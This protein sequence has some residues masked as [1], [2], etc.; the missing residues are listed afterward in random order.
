MNSLDFFGISF[1]NPWVLLLLFLIPV[2]SFLRGRYGGSAAVVFSGTEILEQVGSRRR[3][4]AG[5]FLTTMIYLALIALILAAGRP[6]LGRSVTR[7]QASGTDIMLVLDVSRSMLA[8]DFTIGRQRSNRI[9]AVRMVTERFIDSRP[10][11][12][13]G[14]I[15]FAGRP[16]LVSPLTLH[17]SWLRRNLDRIRIGLVEDGTAIGSAIAMA[18]NRLKD[19][20]QDSKIMVLLTD[21]DNNMGRI[22]PLTAAEAARALGIRIY[23]VG[24]GSHGLVPFPFTD[25]FGR[26]VYRDVDMGFDE[27]VLKQIASLTGGRY[28]RATDTQSLEEIFDDIDQLETTTLETE[29]FVQ[30]RDLFP[31][32]LL[33]GF[34]LLSLEILLSQTV[35]RR[36]P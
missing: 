36:L 24:A 10:H 21:G 30:Y 5:D 12:R 34:G 27:E 11:D 33:A 32:F 3:S 20:P 16:Y 26:T 2:V 15:A 31:W 35:W 4:R 7:T 23:T 17:H 29:Q 18:A 25:Q 19:K 13:L 22:T 1:A 6:Q 14:I 9:E 8:E 28:F